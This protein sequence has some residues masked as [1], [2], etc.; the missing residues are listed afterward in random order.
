M[1]ADPSD[2]EVSNVWWVISG[3]S[4]HGRG[5]DGRT[6]RRPRRAGVPIAPSRSREGAE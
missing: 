1:R 3:S 5:M 2:P 6:S 4:G